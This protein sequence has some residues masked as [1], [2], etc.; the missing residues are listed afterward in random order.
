MAEEES[1]ED[2]EWHCYGYDKKHRQQSKPALRLTHF[3]LEGSCVW[4]HC[5]E[6]AAHQTV[7]GCLLQAPP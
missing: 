2:F 5:R 4:F 1:C 6:L 7:R 3:D